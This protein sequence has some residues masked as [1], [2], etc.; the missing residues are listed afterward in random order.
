MLHN[1]LNPYYLCHPVH[2][3]NEIFASTINKYQIPIQ[4]KSKY[5]QDV[6]LYEKGL[7]MSKYEWF[8]NIDSTNALND[9][10]RDRII[11]ILS[12]NVHVIEE[13]HEKIM[14]HNDDQMK[15]YFN[16]NH[17]TQRFTI[18]RAYKI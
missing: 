13:N 3:S 8:Y 12:R 14:I 6:L 10:K 1:A 7:D 15:K 5:N 18:T 2:G 9:D 11:N 4:N 16:F 17:T